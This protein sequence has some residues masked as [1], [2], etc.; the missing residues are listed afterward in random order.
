MIFFIGKSVY[1]TEVDLLIFCSLFMVGSTYKLAKG[2]FT[3]SNNVWR[4]S[5]F[6]KAIIF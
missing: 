3:L 4:I 2:Q 1:N 5:N 6:Y